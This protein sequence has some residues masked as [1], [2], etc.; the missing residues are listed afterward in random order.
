MWA[1]V[2]FIDYWFEVYARRRIY[3]VQDIEEEITE[4]AQ[5]EQRICNFSYCVC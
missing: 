3:T 1:F 4:N 2:H 5:N